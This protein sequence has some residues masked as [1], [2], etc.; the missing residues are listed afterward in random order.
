MR[1]RQG[2]MSDQNREELRTF[3][4]WLLDIGNG[5]IGEPDAS[6]PE[7]TCWVKIPEAY[8]IPDSDSGLSQLIDFI[9]DDE[10]LQRPTAKSLQEKAIVCPKNQTAD[11]INS[12]VLDML[13][14]NSC[15]FKSND[16]ALPK[17]N[18]GGAT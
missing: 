8:C 7:N 6:D 18:D 17:T 16:E 13:N 1:L 5:N 15:T 11:M 14:G 9:Y 2:S 4:Q 12:K 10:S 3:S